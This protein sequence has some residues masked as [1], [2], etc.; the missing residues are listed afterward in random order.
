MFR[1]LFVLVLIPNALWAIDLNSCLERVNGI[2]PVPSK[3]EFPFGKA[4]YVQ[5]LKDK[6]KIIS[7]RD[8]FYSLKTNQ[9]CKNNDLIL[10]KIDRLI[11]INPIQ[12]KVESDCQLVDSAK[13]PATK[14]LISRKIINDIADS[15]DV[16]I[17]NH[18]ILKN[19]QNLP[20]RHLELLEKSLPDFDKTIEF[21]TRDYGKEIIGIKD[22]KVLF[23]LFSGGYITYN[24]QC[25]PSLIVRNGEATSL[26]TCGAAHTMAEAYLAM[27]RNDQNFNLNIVIRDCIENLKSHFSD[28]SSINSSNFQVEKICKKEENFDELIKTNK[29]DL[30]V[31][32][33]EYLRLQSTSS[34]LFKMKKSERLQ[35]HVE[36]L[37]YFL[38]MCTIKAGQEQDNIYINEKA[39]TK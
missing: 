13:D 5:K 8:E 14:K 19:D 16:I 20:G 18:E 28:Y 27:H 23:K 7:T 17:K 12:K 4:V 26:E 31:F 1:F 33:K 35:S 15:L 2:G 38:A 21:S 30:T 10:K 3:T 39:S 24:D 25:I 36:N 6:L 22:D 37:S 11:D 29:N 34:T 9:V 32:L